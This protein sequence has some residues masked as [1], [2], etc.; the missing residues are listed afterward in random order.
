[1]CFNMPLWWTFSSIAASHSGRQHMNS[2][3]WNFWTILDVKCTVTLHNKYRERTCPTEEWRDAV[4]SNNWRFATIH[5]VCSFPWLPGHVCRKRKHIWKPNFSTHVTGCP[6][7][8]SCDESDCHGSG[9][10]PLTLTWCATGWHFR[11]CVDLGPLLLLDRQTRVKCQTWVPL[12]GRSGSFYTD[13]ISSAVFISN[14]DSKCIKCCE[15]IKGLLISIITPP[16]YLYL[17]L[18]SLR[19]RL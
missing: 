4:P 9:G 13:C 18:F 16:M 8:N 7:S 5:G 14:T 6:I 10:F 15:I 17:H 2:N 1:M 11:G 3:E 12:R 19:C